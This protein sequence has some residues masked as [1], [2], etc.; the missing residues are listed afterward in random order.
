MNAIATPFPDEA[1]RANC[2][3]QRG[4]RPRPERAEGDD[5]RQRRT[6]HGGNGGGTSRVIRTSNAMSSG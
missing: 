5:E 3:Q 2:F 1:P 6:V 4:F